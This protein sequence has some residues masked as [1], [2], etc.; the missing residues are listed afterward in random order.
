NEVPEE[1]ERAALLH[2]AREYIKQNKVGIVTRKKLKQLVTSLQVAKTQENNSENDEDS[3]DIDYDKFFTVISSFDM[4]RIEYEPSIKN[5]KSVEKPPQFIGDET[6][7]STLFKGR[8]NLLVQRLLRNELFSPVRFD[9]TDSAK[10]HLT[11]IKDLRGRTQKEFL[12]FGMLTKTNEGK[13][14]LEDA[15]D[16]IELDFSEISAPSSICTSYCFQLVNGTYN[17]ETEIFHALYIGNPP[18]EKRSETRNAYGNVDF[19]GIQK[20]TTNESLLMLYQEKWQHIMFVV[21]SDVWLDEEQTLEKLRKMFKEYHKNGMTPFAFI[22]IGNFSYEP[23]KLCIGRS[24]R[25]TEMFSALG[26]LISEFENIA[27]HSHFIFVPGPCDPYVGGALPYM[28][29]PE[30]YTSRFKEYVKKAVF[31]S[32]PCRIQFL[33]QEILIYREDV[34]DKFHRNL[35]LRNSNNDPDCY[36]Q[37]VIKSIIDQSHISPFKLSVRP[38]YWEFDHALR[39]YPLPNAVSK[40]VFPS[41]LNVRFIMADHFPQYAFD[42]TECHTFNPGSFNQGAKVQWMHYYPARNHSEHW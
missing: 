30:R 16:R 8:Y 25:Y 36:Y 7:R 6:S 18:V 28:P 23:F 10:F 3:F 1:E 9:N 20:Q 24:R 5:F 31:T 34:I 35:L 22:F 19:L 37:E 15:D 11:S 14:Y 13:Y 27:N 21:V 17:E 4:P 33:T 2:I 12:L 38:V 39:I 26:E 40:R 29:I 32:N 41:F 42:Y